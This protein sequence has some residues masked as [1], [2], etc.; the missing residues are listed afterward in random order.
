MNIPNSLTLIRI[1][2]IPVFILVFYLPYSWTNAAAAVIF[3]AGGLTDWLDG[4]LARR[5]E[6]TSRFGAF[7]DPVA[8][9]LLV[10]VALVLLV[11][12][13]PRAWL[14]ITAAIIIGREI[15]VSGLREFMAEIGQRS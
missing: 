1:L 5:L 3:A 6:Q 15:A 4:F 10:A 8:D 9:K 11:Q 12:A 14:A 7:L 13:D 2:L